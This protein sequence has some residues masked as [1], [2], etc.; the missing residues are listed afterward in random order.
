MPSQ[1]YDLEDVRRLRAYV[2]QSLYPSG[3]SLKAIYSVEVPLE[4]LAFLRLNKRPIPHIG[5]GLSAE[6]RMRLV[7]SYPLPFDPIEIIIWDDNEISIADGQHRLTV[8]RERG[9]RSI[10]V[11]FSLAKKFRPNPNAV[12]DGVVQCQGCPTTIN[13]GGHAWLS[14]HF[15]GWFCSKSCDMAARRRARHPRGAL[16][17]HEAQIRHGIDL[18]GLPLRVAN[19]RDGDPWL[20]AAP[21]RRAA[22]GDEP[23]DYDAPPARDV[24]FLGPMDV[25]DYPSHVGGYQSLGRGKRRRGRSTHHENPRRNAVCPDCGAR[26]AYVNLAG[27]LDCRCAKLDIAQ[28]FE[29]AEKAADA[30]DD[31]AFARWATLWAHRLYGSRVAGEAAIAETERDEGSRLDALRVMVFG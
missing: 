22:A 18:H 7:R 12:T 9:D 29:L 30:G 23:D 4:A 3:S 10:P 5:K 31:A 8:A 19:P 13:P 11:E 28:T 26:D 1:A 25:H 27:R 14:D 6:E 2:P 17:P 15:G 16:V 20:P 24:E 21:A